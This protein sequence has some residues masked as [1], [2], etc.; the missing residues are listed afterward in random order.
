VPP[1]GAV[2]VSGLVRGPSVPGTYRLAWDLVQENVSWFS[3]RGNAR[4]ERTIVVRAAA[5]TAPTASTIDRP[6][7]TLNPPA[8][9]RP[10]LWHAAVVLFRERPLLGVGPDN[11]RRRYEAVLEAGKSGQ[12]Y[13]DTRLH[14]N[15]LYFETLADLGLAGVA[16]LV[17]IGLALVRSGRRHWRSGSLAGL[18]SAVAAGTFF[19]H[20]A[21]DYFFEFTPLLGLF[22]LL[23]GLA[24]ASESKPHEGLR[25]SRP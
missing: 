24:A 5:D 19:V 11:F 14:A 2:D 22:W 20:G 8:P 12:R 9:S 21:L 15:S 25:G 3:E 13:T 10:E 17:W 23:L 16:A 1:G 6:G 18:G 4:A 7:P